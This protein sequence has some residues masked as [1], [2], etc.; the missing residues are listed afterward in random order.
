MCN[1]FTA[2]ATC[3]CED[4]QSFGAQHDAYAGDTELMLSYPPKDL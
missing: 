1:V 3:S 2:L 4:G